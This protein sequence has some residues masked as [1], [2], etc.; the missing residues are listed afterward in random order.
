M[1]SRIIFT[2]AIASAAVPALAQNAT[3]DA[4]AAHNKIA[5]CTGCHG[6]PGY[7]TAFPEVYHVPKLGGQ[8]G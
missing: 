7:K 4:K 5:M 3:G 6:I 8:Q 2:F 1:F